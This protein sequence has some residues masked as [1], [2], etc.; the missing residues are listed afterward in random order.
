ML[1]SFLAAAYD[2]TKKNEEKR[3]MVDALKKLP[4]PFLAKLA[5]REVKLGDIFS[6]PNCSKDGDESWLGKF[7]GTPLAE[8]AMQLEQAELQLEMQ[9]LE[10]QQQSRAESQAS[11]S[12]WD[13]QDQLRLQ[14]KLL[15][16]QLYQMELE[17]EHAA[18]A[19]PATVDT[20]KKKPIPEAGNPGA[21]SMGPEAENS[22]ENMA[23]V[24]TRGPGDAKTASLKK[25]S[26]SPMGKIA[27]A[28]GRELA[29]SDMQKTALP[30]MG[31]LAGAGKSMLSGAKGI[32]GALPSA[33]KTKMLGG[34][35]VGAL[36]GAAATG[37]DQQGFHPLRAIGGALGGAALGGAAGGAAHNIAEKG[38]A[39]G[40]SQSVQQGKNIGGF[41]AGQARAAMPGLSPK[42]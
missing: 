31:T 28:W 18:M 29:R 26:E 7:K 33:Q 37:H 41:L 23:P 39:G 13:Q 9:R 3:A 17:G 20:Q 25:L 35:A 11:N 24:G 19:P 6:A 34:A 5:S 36:G 40:I 16:L 38:L 12:I 32:W 8:Q 4:A 42:V 14:K 21:G 27:D 1:D 10:N 22:E 15:E 2:N 30:S